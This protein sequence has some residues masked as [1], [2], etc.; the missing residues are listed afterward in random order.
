MAKDERGPSSETMLF[1]PIGRIRTPFS[2]VEGTP[3]QPAGARG[4]EGTV[5]VFDE[6][7]AGLKD[8]A[9]FSHVL[10]FYWFHRSGDWSPEVTPFLDDEPRGVFA[11]R[12]PARPNPI[13]L[14]LVRLRRVEGAVLQVEDVDML[15][16]SPLL[17]IKPYLPEFDSREVSGRGWLE[18]N[19]KKAR[20]MR[21]DNRFRP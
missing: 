11:T 7:A 5:E 18:G 19:A 12:A 4:V 1:R 8:L 13:G 3:I 21:A 20:K 2:G 17:D 6:F 16:G 9:G 10:L 14:S 15:D